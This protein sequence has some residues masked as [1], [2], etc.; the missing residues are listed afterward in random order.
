MRLSLT[1]AAHAFP[2][3]AA[4][5]KIPVRFGATA[6]HFPNPVPQGTS[7]L[8]LGLRP[9]SVNLFGRFEEKHPNANQS[10]SGLHAQ[11]KSQA[12]YRL[13]QNGYRVQAGFGCQFPDCD[14]R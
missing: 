7:E 4:K 1:K 3:S 6:H 9:T 10:G 12:G 2:F 14:R 8:S 5:Q 11:L 13:F